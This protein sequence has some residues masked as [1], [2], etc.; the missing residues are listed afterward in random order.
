MKKNVSLICVK[1]LL[2]G[3]LLLF[4]FLF[5]VLPLLMM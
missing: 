5:T 4:L 1:R 3:S 2:R